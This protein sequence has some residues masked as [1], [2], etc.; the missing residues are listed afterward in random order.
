MR[1]ILLAGLFA[2]LTIATAAPAQGQV[3]RTAS[4]DRCSGTIT[5]GGVS[6]V[7]ANGDMSRNWLF[8]QNPINA[9]EPLFVDFGPNHLASAT[10]STQLAP[11]GS[12][13]FLAGVVPG[14]QVNVSA[15]TAGHA[16]VCETGR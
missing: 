1:A 2:A 3:V 12:I 14:T 13:S 8:V 9:T 7:A 15:A 5:T 16:F 10:L 4:G 6:Q 11:G